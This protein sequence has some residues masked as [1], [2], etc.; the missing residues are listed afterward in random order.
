MAIKGIEYPIV[1]HWFQVPKRKNQWT[2]VETQNPAVF[3]SSI[4]D[5]AEVANR[6]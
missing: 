6:A 2:M 1:T 5:V 3:F 4:C